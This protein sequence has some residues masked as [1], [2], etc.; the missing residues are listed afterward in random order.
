MI[1]FS[2]LPL[3]A[4][5]KEELCKLK[6]DFAFQP[7]YRRDGKT[8]YAY[9]ALMRPADKNI[10]DLIEEYEKAGKLHVLEVAT[11]FGALLAYEE[12]GLTD[13]VCINSFPS[14]CFTD[15]ENEVFNE[16]FV[17]TKKKGIVEI[18]EYPLSTEEN[19]RKKK[20]ALDERNVRFAID[21]FGSGYNDMN[22]VNV[23]CPHIV[24]LDRSLISEIH[25]HKEKQET[26]ADFIS[27]FK[28]KGML[29]LAEGVETGEEYEFLLT[30]EVDL[31]QGYYFGRPV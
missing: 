10:V 31:F 23:F 8:M 3:E 18:L 6:I 14:E 5:I 21:D 20:S 17:E 22:A 27:H 13:Y 30:M 19:W 12:R 26:C 15:H 4:S 2:E 16:Y 28:K 25:L 7:I 11:F 24:K 1:D 29:V 9:E